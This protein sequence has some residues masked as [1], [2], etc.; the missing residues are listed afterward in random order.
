MAAEMRGSDPSVRWGACWST[1][2]NGPA[3]K[4]EL[5]A[6]VLE[7]MT[8]ALAAH[9]DQD[10]ITIVIGVCLPAL[11]RYAPAFAATHRSCAVHTHPRPPV[12]D[13]VLAAPYDSQI[14]VALERVGL[15]ATLRDPDSGP[16]HGATARI[17]AALLTGPPR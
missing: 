17:A 15:L 8:G 5:P 4:G 9:G 13:W 7:T 1:S 10:A 16:A 3:R 14:L 11:H 12:A 2:S 6:D